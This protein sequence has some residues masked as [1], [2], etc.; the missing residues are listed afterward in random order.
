MASKEGK[1]Q[2]KNIPRKDWQ[3]LNSQDRLDV[4]IESQ[5]K[6]IDED[7][8]A[9]ALKDSLALQKLHYNGFGDLPENWE[10]SG[11]RRRSAEGVRSE[12][13]AHDR[14]LDYGRADDEIAESVP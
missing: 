9:K 11:R 5:R 8:C 12:L 3:L 14:S 7:C 10:R 1:S 2:V 4:V 6:L 13:E